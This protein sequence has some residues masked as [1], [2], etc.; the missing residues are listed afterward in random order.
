MSLS[1]YARCADNLIDLWP[2]PHYIMKM[3]K[4]FEFYSFSIAIILL[5]FIASFQQ[6][7]LSTDMKHLLIDQPNLNF[8]LF[9]MPSVASLVTLIIFTASQMPEVFIETDQFDSGQNL[10][11]DAQ[12]KS[13]SQMN[14]AII[15]FFAWLHFSLIQEILNHSDI[16]MMANV[17]LGIG[18]LMVGIG[19]TAHRIQRN[20]AIGF[21]TP[22]TIQNPINWQKTH[23][24]SGRLF[25]VFG[26]ANILLNL[27]I[28]HKKTT[29]IF[30]I[31]LPAGLI[32]IG[33]LIGY[34]YSYFIYR[35]KLDQP[36][37]RDKS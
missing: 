19:L 13:I 9:L 33:S 18:I 29:D 31:S 6:Y 5:C 21:R 12:L 15:F 17:S 22:W 3:K 14:L 26:I 37:I 30:L 7:F 20:F 25:L 36:N 2:L 32:I 23:K 16:I 27:Y 1:P 34:F 35:E 24:F 8:L 4:S 11:N 10:K 28:H